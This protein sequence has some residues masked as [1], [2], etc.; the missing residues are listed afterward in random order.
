MFNYKG[1]NFV[2]RIKRKHF[3][4]IECCLSM[5][6][7]INNSSWKDDLYLTQQLKELNSKG[8]LL[9]EISS[10]VKR[11]FSQY[12]WSLITLN[13][14]LKFFKICRHDKNVVVD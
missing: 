13:R 3:S 7:R 5:A 4:K 8:M 9:Q 14:R 11:N 6:V 1:N 10:Y 12:P 2:F